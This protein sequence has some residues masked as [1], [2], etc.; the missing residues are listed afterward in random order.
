MSDTHELDLNTLTW[1]KLE[2]EQ[3]PS[4]SG[5]PLIPC[6]GHRVVSHGSEVYLVGGRFK[7][8]AGGAHLGILRMELSALGKAVAW[9]PV[10]TA[11]VKP[12]ARRGLS[13]TVLGD[14]LAVFGGEDA[15]RKYL[16]DAHVLDLTTMTWRSVGVG[17]SN[18]KAG[19][20]NAPPT[21]RAEHTAAA[22]GD[23]KLLIFGGT[24][25]T[26]KP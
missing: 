3:A 13:A 4:G 14:E 12:S 22:W 18:G 21:P 23:D 26:P 17:G 9:V 16:D 24:G 6:A 25:A 2:P 11:G 10:D 5:V 19:G 8:G 20:K 15:D 7:A 1:R